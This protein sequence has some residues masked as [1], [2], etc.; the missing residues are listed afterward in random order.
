M[1][2]RLAE[3]AAHPLLANFSI[4]VRLSIFELIEV[5]SIGCDAVC[6]FFGLVSF[7]QATTSGVT[8][9]GFAMGFSLTVRLNLLSE[10]NGIKLT[11]YT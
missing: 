8:W 6:V 11:F 7:L 9:M 10:I 4:M 3:L 1:E 2:N 5:N